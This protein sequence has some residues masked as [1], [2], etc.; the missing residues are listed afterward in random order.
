MADTSGSAAAPSAND[1][2]LGNKSQQ[3]VSFKPGMVDK[4]VQV[5]CMLPG[6]RSIR[7]PDAMRAPSV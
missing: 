6:T 2:L 4:S 5:L 3:S 7:P 1:A